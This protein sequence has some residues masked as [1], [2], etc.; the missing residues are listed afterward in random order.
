MF[1]ASPILSDSELI[2]RINTAGDM[3][4]S[5]SFTFVNFSSPDRFKTFG[6]DVSTDFQKDHKHTNIFGS[7]K[8]TIWFAD[9]LKET[10]NLK[11]H[12]GDD[13]YESW[14]RA[15][16]KYYKLLKDMDM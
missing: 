10:Y 8:Y 2:E 3:V 5:Y 13:D 1:V 7:Q 15:T 16:K 11:D 12:R 6:F 9:Y 14:D 4:E